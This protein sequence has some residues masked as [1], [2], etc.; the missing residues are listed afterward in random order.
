MES[1]KPARLSAG[2]DR[3]PRAARSCS[4][5]RSLVSSAAEPGAPSCCASSGRLPSRSSRCT[6]GKTSGQHGPSD[7]TRRPAG[8]VSWASS[9]CSLNRA[10][11]APP[12]FR[13]TRLQAGARPRRSRQRPAGLGA[14]ATQAGPTPAAALR[15]SGRGSARRSEDCS[16]KLRV[17]LDAG[18]PVARKRQRADRSGAR[19]EAAPNAPHPADD[20][21]CRCSPISRTRSAPADRRDSV[22]ARDGDTSSAS[23]RPTCS[24]RDSR[25]PIVLNEW[26]ARDLGV[27]RRRSRGARLLR[28]GGP[29]QPGELTAKRSCVVGI[30]PIAGAAADR[31]LAPRIRASPNRRTLRDWDPPFPIDLEPRPAGRRGVLERAIARR[32]KRSFRSSVGQALWRSRYGALTSIRVDPARRHAARGRARALSRRAPRGP[33]SDRGAA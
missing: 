27:K 19:E 21:A 23:S 4:A 13:S 14:A 10:T 5:R 24:R 3:R 22:F 16:L 9:R 12:S 11:C 8:G 28:L 31:D 25:P 20:R 7:G 30:V 1:A 29:G 26:A 2:S 6:A 33:R 15:E 18:S 32:R 17:L